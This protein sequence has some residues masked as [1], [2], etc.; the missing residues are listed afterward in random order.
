MSFPPTPDSLSGVP[1]ASLPAIVLDT[2]TT[3]LDTSADRVVEIGAVRLVG[4][5][6]NGETYAELINPGISIPK[7]STDIH[8]IA[9]TDVADA[10]V[11]TDGMDRFMQW[12]GASII[13]G[14]SIGFDIAILKAE[15]ARHGL[16][17]RTPRA[18]DVRHLVQVL[19]PNLPAESLETTAGWLGIEVT[20]RHRA[21]GDALL[22]ARVFLAL[23]PKLVDKGIVT[24]AQAER[25]CRMRSSQIEGEARAGWEAPGGERGA[26]DSIAEYARIDSFPYRHRVADLMNAPPLVADSQMPLKQALDLMVEKRVSSLF[27][28]PVEEGGAHGI[29]TE[30]D[31]L[32]AVAEAGAGAFAQPIGGF[33]QRPLVTVDSDEFAYRALAR[34]TAKGFRHL[35][36]ADPDGDLAGALSARDLLRQRADDA[37]SLG[38]DLEQ[39]ETAA[40]LGHVWS[41]LT[42][43]ARALDYEDVDAR[44]IAAII[45]R[46]LRALTQ[47]ACRLAEREFEAEGKGTAPVPYAMLV[48]GSGGRGE[49]LLAMDQDNAIVYA[50]G[51]PDGADAWFEALGQ[52]V[53]DIL[54]QVGVSYCKGGVMASNAAWRKDL[55]GWRE[56]VRSWVK[57]SSPK[58]LLNCDI[59]FDARRAHGDADLAETLRVDAMVIAREAR[60]FLK[61]LALNAGE[62][63][64]PVGWLGRLRTDHGRVDLKAGG[65]MPIFSAARV[66]ALEH[67]IR[68]RATVKRLEE[69]KQL[70][71]ATERRIDN[72]VEAHRILLGLILRQ[73]L[74]DIDDGVALSNKV[75]PGDLTSFEK[76][77]LKWALDQVPSVSDLLGTP[78][79]G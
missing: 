76:Q 9:D 43:V 73:Q 70:D 24:L 2:E 42:A 69:A 33:G 19:Q 34:M 77:E 11:F 37:V 41:G 79:M 30:R 29:I 38:D 8:T 72:L 16:D 45:S 62:Y 35:G 47:Q 25:G 22:T 60:T 75:A 53:A 78:A 7:A 55:D 21:L 36:V 27:L 18:L 49:S 48:L 39:A 59:F 66:V 58:D 57:R 15:H 26:P 51:A 65:I 40:E 6:L 64:V 20:D 46:E 28:A 12:S 23:V 61:F 56:T 74:R 32:R 10:P 71:V 68:P 1:L 14:Y 31:V 44:D 54:N 52:R 4:G 3:G 50:N 13:I 67:G 17:W 5:K 63:D